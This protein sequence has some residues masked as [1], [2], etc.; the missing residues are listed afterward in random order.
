MREV[1]VV[2]RILKGPL[3]TVGEDVDLSNAEDYVSGVAHFD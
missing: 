3:S 2:G 1:R